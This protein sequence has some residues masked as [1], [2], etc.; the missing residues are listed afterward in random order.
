MA[1]TSREPALARAIGID[2]SG[3]ET[4]TAS[5]K[6]VRVYLAKGAAPPVEVPP[7]PSP[8]K[9]WTRKGSLNGW[10][11][12]SR[13]TCLRWSASTTAFAPAVMTLPADVYTD[14]VRFERERRLIF[15]RVSMML[16]AGC[17]LPR[18]AD[19]KNPEATGVPAIVVRGGDGGARTFFIARA[20]RG[21]ALPQRR[22]PFPR[23]S[24]PGS[25]GGRRGSRSTASRPAA[26]AGCSSR[27]CSRG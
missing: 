27:R 14:P 9:Y 24:V 25:S 22:A 4:P 21:A 11:N 26:G 7:P 10:W 6:G 8:R 20:H 2:S 19:Y 5:L 17:E 16:A 15:R 23:G 13:R 3:A 18:P 12:G 1:S